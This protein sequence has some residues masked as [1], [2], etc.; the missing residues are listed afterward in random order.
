MI[1]CTSKSTQNYFGEVNCH[2]RNSSLALRLLIWMDDVSINISKC[3][4]LQNQQLTRVGKWENQMLQ[5]SLFSK[6]TSNCSEYMLC[7]VFRK[8]AF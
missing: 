1:S 4:S 7:T 8:L 3:V 6:R 2:D 5:I